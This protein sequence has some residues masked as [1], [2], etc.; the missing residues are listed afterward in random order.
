MKKK[1]IF[2]I[3]TALLNFSI[4]DIFAQVTYFNYLDHTS[5]WNYTV[6]TE[7]Y[8]FPCGADEITYSSITHYMDG[9]TLIGNNWYYKL[10][11]AKTDSI[12]CGGYTSVTSDIYFERG[13]RED[14]QNRIYGNQG[15]GDLL[16]WD[17][18]IS[19]GDTINSTCPVINI[20]TVWLGSRPL[21]RFHCDCSINNKIIEGIGG[22]SR[23]L[24]NTSLCSR[25]I[26]EY[27]EFTC[28]SKQTDLIQFGSTFQCGV[29]PYINI[30]KIGSAKFDDIKVYPNPV[31]SNLTISVSLS[32]LNRNGNLRIVNTLGKVILNKKIDNLLNDIDVSSYPKGVYYIQIISKEGDYVS[33]F[34]KN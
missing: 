13:I 27:V 22:G 29:T 30:K 4:T 32:M 20:D 7:L 8:N 3:F 26:H 17:F 19:I 24:L 9:D 25:L 2:F 15:G 1:I 11:R 21:R 28:Y 34:I 23:G 33:Q 6:F 5:Q 16:I 18:N 12:M 14:S 31:N 10:Y